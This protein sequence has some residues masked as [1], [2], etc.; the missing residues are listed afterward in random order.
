[1]KE[2]FKKNERLCSK[3]SIDLLFNSG[4]SFF[5]YPFKVKWIETSLNYGS[6]A[7]IM[8]VI[9]KKYSKKAVERN[10][11]RRIIKEVYRKSKHLLYDP[12]EKNNK[13]VFVALLYIG[14]EFHNYHYIEEKINVILQ[15]LINS[16]VID[17]AE[18]N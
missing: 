11:I 18:V 3:K 4:N 10:K 5:V 2:T 16:V 1:M 12:L 9:P 17:N 13:K 15:R 8:I 14:K 7:E 6:P